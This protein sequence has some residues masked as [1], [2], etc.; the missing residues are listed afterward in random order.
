VRRF[1][2][3][4]ACSVYG[5][6]GGVQDE[7]SPTVPQTAHDRSKLR[8]EGDIRALADERFA[9]VILRNAA[10]YGASPRMRFD[11]VF[12]NLAGRA[13]TNGEIRT[14]SDGNAWRPMVHVNDICEAIL[15]AIEAPREAVH[16][17]IFNV[18][19]D[20]QNY[21]LRD[22]ADIVAKTFPGR[23]AADDTS[24]AD[25]RSHRV[26]FAK[27]R[28]HLPGFRCRWT[29][30]RGARQLREIFEE[31]AMPKEVFAYRAFTR[32]LQLKYLVA[33]RQ[34]D[35]EFYFREPAERAQRA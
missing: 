35:K 33:T 29:A 28:R 16:N 4:S 5:T 32:L 6:G 13:W 3:S 7:A 14:T 1:I 9:P 21:R 12:N 19:S 11:T 34:V 30:E 31:I 8:I 22:L 17:Q 18:G 2:Y 25:S 15:L 20:E 10:A 23:I 27:I 24:S 26:S